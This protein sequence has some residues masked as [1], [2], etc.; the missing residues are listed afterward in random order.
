MASPLVAPPL[1]PVNCL[2]CLSEKNISEKSVIVRGDRP[3]PSSSW[4]G[5]GFD[6]PSLLQDRSE[7]DHMQLGML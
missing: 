6:F 1:L 2:L 3:D 7:R 4:C 5:A